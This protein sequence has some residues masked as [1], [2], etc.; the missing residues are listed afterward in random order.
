MSPEYLKSSVGIGGVNSTVFLATGHREWLLLGDPHAAEN[1]LLCSGIFYD[2]PSQNEKF[3]TFLH[4]DLIF[5]SLKKKEKSL[6]KWTEPLGHAGLVFPLC[7][8]LKLQVTE[9]ATAACS[10]VKNHIY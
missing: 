4:I 5:F 7:C 3:T 10:L 6:L 8:L 9:I 1:H 2:H